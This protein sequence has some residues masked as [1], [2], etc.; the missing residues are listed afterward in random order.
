[1]EPCQH[2][3]DAVFLA[4][5]HMYHKYFSLWDRYGGSKTVFVQLTQVWLTQVC[6]LACRIKVG[7]LG[8]SSPKKILKFNTLRWL[9]HEAS[10]CFSPG[11]ETEFWF[12]SCTHALRSVSINIGSF[13]HTQ[14]IAWRTG[15]C[16][17]SVLLH[18][19]SGFYSKQH[20]PQMSGHHAQ[21]LLV[22]MSPHAA[23]FDVWTVKFVQA[24]ICEGTHCRDISLATTTH[25]YGI[26]VS[27]N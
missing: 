18:I 10:L 5:N 11:M 19:W 1:M 27:T 25:E 17:Q 24:Q 22:L 16:K 26:C 2:W 12:A 7:G 3:A 14:R 9:L 15:T 6:A 4:A 8:T 23:L 20:Q 13:R 21:N